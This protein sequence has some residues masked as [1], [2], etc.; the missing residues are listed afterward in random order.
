MLLD[1]LRDTG[2]MLMTAKVVSRECALIGDGGSVANSEH[3]TPVY[4]L[5]VCQI[6]V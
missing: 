4:V 2:P 5:Y 3:L 1:S 6:L